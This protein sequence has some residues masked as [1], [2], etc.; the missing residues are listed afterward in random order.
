MAVSPPTLNHELVSILFRT[1]PFYHDR[2]SRKAVQECLR[3][4]LSKDE[5]SNSVQT[6]LALFAEEASKTN[7]AASNALVLVE[8]GALIITECGK[9]KQLWQYHWTEIITLHAQVLETCIAAHGRSS[10]KRSALLVTRRALRS[11]FHG[12]DGEQRAEQVIVQLTNASSRSGWRTA[13]L[14]GVAAGVCARRP[15]LKLVMEKQKSHYI[16]FFLR[17][18]IGSRV[19]VPPHIANGLADFFMEFVTSEDMQREI[20]PAIEKALLRAPEVV[21]NDL[22]SPLIVSLPEDI[23]MGPLLADRL[24]KPLLSNMKSSNARIRDGATSTFVDVAKHSRDEASLDTII[25]EV[26]TPLATSKLTVTEHRILHSRVLANL[27]VSPTQSEAMCKALVAA[28]IKEPSEVALNAELQALSQ[29]LVLLAMSESESHQSCFKACAESVCKGLSDKKPANR[30]AWILM[31]GEVIWRTQKFS[32]VRGVRLFV[33]MTIPKM[34]EL[35][36]EVTSNV[37]AAAQ[38]GLVVVGFVLTASCTYTMNMIESS[39]IITLIRKASIYEQACSSDPKVSFLLNHRIYS[40]ITIQE[41]L[42]WAIR[43]LSACASYIS[44][45]SDESALGG[46]WAQAFIH[47]VTAASVPHGVRGEAVTAL[48]E[49]YL[50]RAST[51]SRDIIKGLWLWQEQMITAEQDSD[52]EAS[53]DRLHLAIKAICPT[54]DQIKSNSSL[55]QEQVQDQLIAMITLCRQPLIPHISWIEVCLAT[56]QDPGALVR[57]ASE[58]CLAEIKTHAD[59]VVNDLQRAKIEA[60]MYSAAAE[61]AFVAQDIIIPLLIE[62]IQ[63]DLSASLLRSYSPTDIAVSRTPE[64]T[65]FIDVLSAKPQENMID[66]KAKDYD[67]LK[68]EAEVRSQLAVKK[69]QGRKLSADER[70]K[71]NAQLKKEAAIRREVLALEDRLRRGIGIIRALVTGPP[72]DAGLWFGPCAK[73][74]LEIIRANAGLLIGDLAEKAYLDLAKLVSTRLG[75]LRQFTGVATLRSLGR[76]TVPDSMQQEP[77]GELVTRVLYRLQFLSEQRPFD[78]ISLM[79][80]LPLAM[81][82]LQTNGVGRTEPDEINE[83]ITLALGFFALHADI[84]SDGRLPRRETLALLI[85]SLQQYAQYYKE[86]KDCLFDVC[87]SI[88]GNINGPEISTLLEGAIVPQASVRTS[89]L[90]AIREYLDLT[91]LDFSEEIWIAAHDDV[92]ENVELAWAIWKENALEALPTDT[93]KI[94][95]YLASKDPQLRRASSKA[96]A[97]CVGDHFSTTL[98]QLEDQYRDLAKPR[99]PERDEFGMPKKTDLTD[100]WE[101]RSGIALTFKAFSRLFEPDELVS[102]IDFLIRSQALADRNPTVRDQMIDSATAIINLH[103]AKFVE[104]LMEVFESTLD[105]AGSDLLNEAVV[106]LYGA[107]GRHLPQ[108]DER[109]PKVVNRLFSTLS[110]PSESVQYAVAGCLP[111]LIRASL[112]YTS[113]YIQSMLDQLLQAKK[114]AARRGAAY[115]LAGVVSGRGLLALREYRIMSTLKSALDNKKDQNYRQGGLMAYELMSL[116]LGRTFEPYVIQ[117]VPQLLNG[118][119]DSAADVREAC[120]DTAKTCF[121]GLSSYGVKTVLP[122]LL[123][124]LEESQWRS[125]KGACDLLGAMAYLDPQQLALS[126]PDIIPP[127]T[128]VL[129]D[130]HKEVRASANRSLQRF[131]EVISNPEVKALVG[132]LLKALSDPTKYTDEALD[133]LIKISFVHYLDAPSLALIVRILERG[134]GD[135]SATKR[136]AAQIIGSLAHLTDRKD[137]TLHLPILVSGLRMAAVDPVPSTRATASKALGS[138]VEKLGE[139]TLPDLIPSLMTTLKSDSGAGDRL[140]SA[141]ALSEVLAGLGTG[142]LEETLPTILQ[143]VTSSKPSVRE[144]FMSLFIYLP[145]CFGNSFAAYLSRIIPPILSGLA[146]EIESIRETSLR[147]GRL[148]VKNFA[149]KAI[150]LLL[151]ELDRGLGDD[152]Y[153]IRLSSVELVGDL[154]FNLTGINGKT[155]QDEDESAPETSASLLEVLG[156]EKRNKILS[157]LYICRCDTSGLVRTAAINVWKALVATPRTLKELVPTLTATLIRRLASANME[158]KIIAGN[159]LGE[160]IRKAG[161]GVLASLLPTLEEGLQ[162]STDS[163]NKQGICIAL[164]EIISSAS[165][166]TLEDY[167]KTLISVVRVALVDSDDEVREAAAEAFDS[168]QKI[169]GKKAVD[170]VLPYLLNLLRTESEAQTALAALL[171]LLTDNTRSNII[172]PNL[173]PTLLIAPI[174]PFNAKAIASLAEVAGSAI[175]RRLPIILNTLMDSI[176][177]C[178]DDELTAELETSFDTI[179]DSVD[180]FDGLNTAMSVMLALVK[181]DDHRK[182]AAA[183]FRL[184]QFFATTDLDFSRYHQDLIRVLLLSFDDRDPEVVRAAWKALSDLTKRLRKEEMEALAPYT[185]TVLQ[186]VGVAGH[187]LA[188]FSLPKGIGAILPIFLQGLMNGTADQRTN[189]ALAISDII[190]RTSADALKQFVTQITGP[191]IRVVSER[192]VDVKAAILLTLNNLLEKIPT[193]LKPFLPQLQRTFAKS[194][195]DTSSEIIRSRAAKALGTLITLT[196]RIDPLIAELVAGSKTPD[197]GVQNAMLRALYEVISKSGSNMSEASRTAILGLVDS[198][199]AGAEES[200]AI[201]N[202]RLVGA[203]IK[204]LPANTNATNLIKQRVLTSHM[205]ISSLLNLNSILFESSATLI[206]PYAQETSSLICQGIGSKNVSIADNSVLAAGKYLLSTVDHGNTEHTAPVFEAL[207]SAISPGNPVD[208]RRLSLVVVRTVSRTHHSAVRP[209]LHALAQPIFASVRDPVIPVKLA[210]EAAFLEIFSV[211]EH[212]NKD[213][214]KYTAGPG[215]SLNPTTKRSMQDYF[216]R[217]AMRLGGQA[218]ERKEAE[219]GQGGLGLSNDERED[220]REIW[221]FHSSQDSIGFSALDS[222]AIPHPDH[223]SSIV[224]APLSSTPSPR[225]DECIKMVNL[226]TQKRLASSVVGCGKRKIWLDPNEVNEISNANSRQTIRKLVSDGLIIRK[227]VTMHSRAR[228]RD[229]TAARRIGRHRGFGKRKG[230]ADARMPSQVMWMRR[231]RVLRRLLVKYRASGKIDKHLYHELYHLSKGNTF[232]HKRALVEH[233]HKAKAEKQRERILK[234]ERQVKRD[235]TKAARERRQERITAKRQALAGGDE[236]QK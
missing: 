149:T 63:T 162:T 140:G 125:K 43:A 165:Q 233:I 175:T 119:G 145:A 181:N 144:G 180:E 196:P 121:S 141:Q 59:S 34:L 198:D 203:L 100:P 14:L 97:A 113:A 101:A 93:P 158:Q 110:T 24:A 57:T 216:K 211:V 52:A 41:D 186:Q 126:L 131:G 88:S 226:R 17:E 55:S 213:F 219:G 83:Q 115:G 3:I 62:E 154:L 109:V 85:R 12:K 155:E 111:P 50:Q 39:N 2:P 184:G 64:G 201:T 218:R 36:Q 190:D 146:D 67:T 193:H 61:L 40:K 200:M 236:E 33:E 138:L 214:D 179:L 189:A 128:G 187:D 120:L 209:H 96:L 168:L 169:F 133:S 104:S 4:L 65:T 202:A 134:L 124:G 223:D 170:Q 228:A 78:T 105:K 48:N 106:V 70:A 26:L 69:D 225:D 136:K 51:V 232:K 47:F 94:F 7:L 5:Y 99:L 18:I 53:R 183:S 37:L 176:V 224:A 71:V 122:T 32:D 185:R 35:Y 72:T 10:I 164:R 31:V 45:A 118:F 160:L 8:W 77:L 194:L 76:S 112:S 91:D 13:V 130:S 60:A 167:E 150:D 89:T 229:L 132:I 114:Y 171:T 127:L 81:T 192:S 29:H 95:P 1:Y 44:S 191:L 90:Q 148:L 49:C 178:K 21:L 151:P 153:R 143:N 38:S 212:E 68:W 56:G 117:I 87:R 204:T 11:A 15:H 108:G 217:V 129:N 42:R 73:V 221:S 103:G 54:A 177:A 234:E 84:F 86:I 157:S 230:T 205:S 207:A 199:T 137:V 197:T 30:K 74:L 79:Y 142:R 174:T 16:S 123:E 28:A 173:I 182:R 156:E 27:D 195:A 161:E 92:D 227:P 98:H 163:D 80:I 82:V 107:L 208:T 102:F 66:K 215:A 147:A 152:N 210:A 19:P 75:S 46:A 20:A 222:R 6:L 188:G 25:G 58:R 231:L 166:D 139:D 172:L 159:A 220:E 22:I 135:R 9:R 116:I 235:K 206:E 23:D